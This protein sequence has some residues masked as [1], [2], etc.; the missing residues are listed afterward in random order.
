MIN[1]SSLTIRVLS[2]NSLGTAFYTICTASL[3]KRELPCITWH[4]DPSPVHAMWMKLTICPT[5]SLTPTE[6]S[7]AHHVSVRSPPS[8][9][10]QAFS[11]SHIQPSSFPPTHQLSPPVTFLLRCLHGWFLCLRRSW[12][13]REA[14]ASP[15]NVSF[16][17][18]HISF[19][20]ME[21]FTIFCLSLCSLEDVH[22][23]EDLLDH[24]DA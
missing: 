9:L 8:P 17:C 13:P 22:S 21:H 10:F 7:R 24:Q 2:W 1:W 3:C 18:F 15:P 19:P 4:W 16:F 14:S 12:L 5:E 11:P 23:P 6:L 20:F